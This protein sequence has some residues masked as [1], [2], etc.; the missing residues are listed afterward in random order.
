MSMEDFYSC[1]WYDWSLWMNK[2]NNDRRKRLE[3][4]EVIK[5][6]FR[7]SLSL[8]YNWNRGDKSA[9]LTPQDFWPLSYDPANTDTTPEDGDMDNIE[10]TIKRLESK[11]KNKKRSG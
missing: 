1:T 11:S 2:I 4:H 3:D 6:M 5:E 9:P 7:S 10:E 8:Y